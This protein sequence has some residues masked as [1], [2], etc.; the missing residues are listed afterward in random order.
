ML[1]TRHEGLF[2]AAYTPFDSSG[3][4]KTEPIAGMVD[5]LLRRH[6]AGLYVC[7]STGEGMSLTGEERKRVAAAYVAAAAGRVPVF[8][9]VGHNSLQEAQDLAR[10]AQSI[11]ASAISATCP[12]YFKITSVSDLVK[13]MAIVAAGAPELPFYYY[14]IPS[15]T[16]A[17]LNMRQFLDQAKGVIPN[18][19]GIKFTSTEVHEFQACLEY[20][21]RRFQV[22]WGCDEMLLSALVV[23]CKAAIGSTYNIASP[24]Y[25][26]LLQAFERGDLTTARQL[27]L[28]AVEMIEM[29]QNYPF[30]AA[31]KTILNRLGFDLGKCRFP[32]PMLSEQQNIELKRHIDS[33]PFFG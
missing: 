24:L 8:V 6:V 29:V 17:K 2:A 19:A 7:G 23:G 32:Q 18:L 28:Q 25:W 9:Q 27:Q 1:D 3:Q 22:M 12:S 4:V 15:L 11:G 30:H 33:L 14:H 16:G 26:R 21:N 13:S 10:H 31:M 5:W 20:D